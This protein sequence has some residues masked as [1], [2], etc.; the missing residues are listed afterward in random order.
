MAFIEHCRKSHS[1]VYF[2]T[3]Y[4]T[5]GGSDH[6]V[7]DLVISCNKLCDFLSRETRKF[8]RFICWNR[9]CWDRMGIPA[10][11]SRCGLSSP[12]R[13]HPWRL[14]VRKC[15]K[16]WELGGHM[17]PSLRLMAQIFVW[18]LT[19]PI[20]LQNGKESESVHRRGVRIRL[21]V[22]PVV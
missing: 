2:W 19:I 4:G 7:R 13:Y 16:S 12:F 3:L 18:S 22:S 8:L 11:D 6:S 21:I 5:L 17:S 20:V 1:E 10:C 15:G 14:V 9:R